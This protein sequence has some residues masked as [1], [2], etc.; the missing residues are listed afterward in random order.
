VG[1]RGERRIRNLKKKRSDAWNYLTELRDDGDEAKA[2]HGTRNYCGQNLACGGTSSLGR[3]RC[4][5]HPLYI[6][7]TV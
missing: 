1:N 5:H 7:E 6:D 4:A 2:T 3:H